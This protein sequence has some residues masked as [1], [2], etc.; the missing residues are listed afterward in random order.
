[1]VRMADGAAMMGLAERLHRS[2]PAD[3]A[4]PPGL[5]FE[6]T[7][8]SAGGAP[9]DI[10]LRHIGNCTKAD[11]AYGNGVAKALGISAS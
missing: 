2:Q 3:L 1:M 6:N 9:K 5:L 8:W 7:A 10:Q 4:G 11:P